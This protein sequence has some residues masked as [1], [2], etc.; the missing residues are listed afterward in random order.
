MRYGKKIP[1]DYVRILLSA[2]DKVR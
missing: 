1:L 2:Y